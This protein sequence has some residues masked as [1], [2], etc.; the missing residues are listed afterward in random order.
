MQAVTRE[1]LSVRAKQADA[2]QFPMFLPVDHRPEWEMLVQARPNLL[3]D[4]SASATSEMLG[5]LNPH[6]RQPIIQYD[7]NTGGPVPQPKEGTLVLVEVAR[8][9]ANQQKQML[10][11]L[12]QFNGRALVQVVSTTSEPLFSKV[13]AGAF[14]DNLYYRLNIVRIDL[15]GSSD[16]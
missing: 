11:W 15:A 12:N 14:L 1:P 16:T 7:P 8:L 6:L 2:R 5:A 13:E 4:G 10:Q 9:G 3:L